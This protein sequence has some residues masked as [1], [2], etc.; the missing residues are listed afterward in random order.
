M[1]KILLAGLFLSGCASVQAG[2][3]MGPNG[4]QAH[5]LKCSGMG[6]TIEKCYA[7]AGSLCPKGYTI[8]DRSEGPGMIIPAGDGAFMARQQ[9]IAIECK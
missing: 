2:Q 9:G 6:R 8:I 5:S 4:G 3:F 1:K 7:A